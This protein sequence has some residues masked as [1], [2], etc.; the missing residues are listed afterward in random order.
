MTKRG[1]ASKKQEASESEDN[2]EEEDMEE[3]EEGVSMDD[4][5]S[6]AG[7]SQM[8]ASPPW[9]GFRCIFRPLVVFGSSAEPRNATNTR[10]VALKCL[11]RAIYSPKV[12]FPFRDVF[13]R[14]C[15]D[16]SRG[17]TCGIHM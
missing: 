16:A 9:T 17:F 2:G 7:K 12:L 11:L 13:S 1:K 5:G 6:D 14:L 15:Y 3:E 4:D 8:T 10:R